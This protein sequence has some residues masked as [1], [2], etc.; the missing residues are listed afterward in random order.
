MISS[1]DFKCS[2]NRCYQKKKNVNNVVKTEIWFNQNRLTNLPH[3]NIYIKLMI[4][5]YHSMNWICFIYVL[6]D[7]ANVNFN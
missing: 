3:N 4:T 7:F 2:G 6:Y 5:L 1:N